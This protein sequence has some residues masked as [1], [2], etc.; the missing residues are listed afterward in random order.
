MV[1]HENHFYQLLRG[2][3]ALPRAKSTV[4][5]RRRLDGSVQ[6]L[7]RGKELAYEEFDPLSKDRQVAV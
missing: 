7:H 4:T 1:R 5:V 2:G 6:I 3:Q